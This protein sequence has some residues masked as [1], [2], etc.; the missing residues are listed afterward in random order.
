MGQNILRAVVD[1]SQVGSVTLS[2]RMGKSRGYLAA[3]MARR[4]DPS[5]DLLSE[6]C[7]AAGHRLTA[8]DRNSGESIPID[9]PER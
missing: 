9:P 2:L 1:S 5:I 3:Q 7:H 8:R 4:V 6:V